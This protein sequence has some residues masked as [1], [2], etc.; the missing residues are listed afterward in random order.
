[1]RA[2]VVG[3]V[4]VAVALLLGG[5]DSGPEGPGTVDARVVAGET[6]AAAAVLEVRGRGVQ[7]FEGAGDT[8]IYSAPVS[9]TPPYHRVVLVSPD[10]GGMRF[11]IRV[12]DRGARLP[13]GTVVL[14]ADTANAEV[15]AAGLE[16]R[17]ER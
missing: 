9:G 6:G 15:S 10:A 2:G 11:R 12:E 13:T 1:M 3:A 14:A 5:C 8:R 16:L 7:G 17:V 4:G